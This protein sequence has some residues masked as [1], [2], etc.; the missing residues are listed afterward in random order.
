MRFRVLVLVVAWSLGLALSLD[1]SRVLRSMPKQPETRSQLKRPENDRSFEFTYRASIDD[2]P[3]QSKRVQVWIPLAMSDA[4]Q[5]TIVKRISGPVPTRVTREPRYGNRMLYA[6]IHNPKKPSFAFSV[7]YRVTRREYS[8]GSY[9]SLMRYNG[10][11]SRTP[12]AAERLLQPDRLVPIDGKI[13]EIAEE[14]TRDHQGAGEKA[15]AFY[16]YVFKS[17]RYDKSGT[18]WGRGD[19]LWACDAK[20]GNCTDFHSLFISLA[21]AE[22]I[23]A[24]F[25]M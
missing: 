18:G 22:H 23:P 1:S 17:M 14:T 2:L 8:K 16:E 20:R 5:K 9:D 7:K 25:E 21:R 19:S 4:N 10:L 11:Q 24:R 3:Q 13:K 12:P 6:E 15:H